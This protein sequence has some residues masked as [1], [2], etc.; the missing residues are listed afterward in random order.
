M[1]DN[2]DQGVGQ[3]HR[4]GD[5]LVGDPGVG[6]QQDLHPLEPP[7]WLL[8]AAHQGPKLVSFGLAEVDPIP[9]V[10]SKCPSL[11]KGLG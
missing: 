4:G 6:G 10:H 3:E 1:F 8:A 9:Y 2:F 11:W 7:H 5:G